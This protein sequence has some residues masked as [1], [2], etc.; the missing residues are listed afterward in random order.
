MSSSE[1]PWS[2]RARPILGA[3]LAGQLLVGFFVAP[4]IAECNP[5][6]ADT[7]FLRTAPYAQRILIGRVVDAQPDPAGQGS[8]QDGFTFTLE[9]QQ[10]LRG[11][12]ITELRVDH[13]ETGGCIRWLSAA[14]GDLIALAFETRGK[15][16]DL[17]SATAA[18][19]EGRPS[20]SYDALTLAEVMAVAAAPRPPNTATAEVRRNPRSASGIAIG[21]TLVGTLAML[22]FTGRRLRSLGRDQRRGDL[23]GS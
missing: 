16:T 4:A 9:V 20:T 7:S 12:S 18:W 1:K 13:L 22:P 2:R 8:S 10:V 17:A 14:D 3:A 11:P 6:G 23:L 21:A 5:P 19:I 15:R